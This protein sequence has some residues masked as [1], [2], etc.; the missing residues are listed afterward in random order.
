VKNGGDA[1]AIWVWVGNARQILSNKKFL[2]EFKGWW[3]GGG[4]NRI[5]G[6]SDQTPQAERDSEKGW[7]RPG[8]LGS[9][10]TYRP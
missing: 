4:L 7:K 8:K 9:N 2:A 10:L 1:N 6:F 3:L 5:R